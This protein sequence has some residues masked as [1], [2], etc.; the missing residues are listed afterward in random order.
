QSTPLPVD[1]PAAFGM[2]TLPPVIGSPPSHRTADTS[3]PPLASAPTRGPR[4]LHHGRPAIRTFVFV[5]VRLFCTRR[6]PTR[7]GLRAENGR[8]QSVFSLGLVE[9]RLRAHCRQ[10]FAKQLLG[11]AIR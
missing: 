7:T 10:R 6:T 1:R 4:R 9:P 2:R 8:R 11:P 3:L 5:P